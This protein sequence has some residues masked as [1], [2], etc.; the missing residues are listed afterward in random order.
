[1]KAHLATHALIIGWLNGWAGAYTVDVPACPF[2]L[3]SNYYDLAGL[4]VTG[5][6]PEEAEA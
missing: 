6:Y 5:E 2:S 4:A 1:M 3:L